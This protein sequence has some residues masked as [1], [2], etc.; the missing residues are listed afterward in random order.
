MAFDAYQS[1]ALILRYGLT[2]L[3]AYIAGRAAYMTLRDSRNAARIRSGVKQDGVLARLDVRVKRHARAYSLEREGAVGSGLGA[4]IRVT[5][6][7]LKRRQFYYEIV[8]GDLIVTA[9]K[10]TSLMRRPDADAV[11]Q[12]TIKP[13]G[14]FIAEGTVFKYTIYRQKATPLSPMTRRAYGDKLKNVLSRQHEPLEAYEK[15]SRK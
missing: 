5:S 4:D 8:N 14:C 2:A 3:G 10:R 15:H 9:L 7:G 6:A 13:G 11:K 12:L 1:A